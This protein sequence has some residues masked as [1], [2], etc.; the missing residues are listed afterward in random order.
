MFLNALLKK[1]LNIIEVY[2]PSVA[3][4]ILFITFIIQIFYRYFIGQPLI[5]PMEVTLICFLVITLLGACYALRDKDHV[6]FS[7]LYDGYSPRWQWVSKIAGNLMMIIAFGVSLSPTYE[8]I[9]FMDFQKT[10]ALSIRFD[11]IY[12]TYMVFAII[13]I[14]RLSYNTYQLIFNKEAQS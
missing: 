2:I 8:F 12:M 1:S 7:S 14:G 5:W 6:V 3:F 4:I 11:Y 13:V 9:S 10:T